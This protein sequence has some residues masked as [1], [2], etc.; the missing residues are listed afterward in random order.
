[1]HRRIRIISMVVKVGGERKRQ[2]VHYSTAARRY[3]A[4]S[5][6]ENVL[7]LEPP[8]FSCTVVDVRKRGIFVSGVPEC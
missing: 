8:T 5:N 6:R 7:K 3:L 1:M 2:T 4:S